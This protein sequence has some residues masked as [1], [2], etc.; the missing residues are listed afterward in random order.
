MKQNSSVEGEDD[1]TLWI[2]FVD[3]YLKENKIRTFLL[4]NIP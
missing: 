1:S 4:P 2:H 3:L